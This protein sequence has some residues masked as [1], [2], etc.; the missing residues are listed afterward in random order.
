MK[1][2]KII[3]LLIALFMI[4]SCVISVSA[5]DCNRCGRGMTA[6]GCEFISFDDCVAVPYSNLN[7]HNGCWIYYA[8]TRYLCYTCP[9]IGYSIPRINNGVVEGG[10]ACVVEHACTGV[11]ESICSFDY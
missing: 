8:P 4:C 11:V 5:M 6:V 7:T 9:V 3:S 1:N 2:R 10:H